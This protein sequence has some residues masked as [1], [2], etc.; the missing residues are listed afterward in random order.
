MVVLPVQEK[1]HL[2][3]RPGGADGFL[4]VQGI[5]PLAGLL[6]DAAAALHEQRGRTAGRVTN[7]LAGLRIQQARQQVGDLRRRVVFPGLAAR[8][9]RELADQEFIG[10]A[11]D[12]QRPHARQRKIQLRLGKVFQ[13]GAQQAVLL[14][15][16]A[17]L[18]GIEADVLKD[19]AQFAA[20][21][22]FQSRQRLIDALAV[23]RLVTMLVEG[24]EVGAL[25]QGEALLLHQE[26]DLLLVAVLL[27][28]PGV[29]IIIDIGHEF[30]EQ[31][32]KDEVLVHA[33]VDG[34]AKGVA[35]RPDGLVDLFLVDGGDRLAHAFFLS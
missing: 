14:L 6:E 32:D 19:V 18:I 8:I 11:D 12:V 31:H 23:A 30:Q 15:F 24:P 17:Q 7:G 16:L 33:G 21:G 27:H 2:G 3:Q 22:I 10:I 34:T 4:P 5:V 9:G 13:Q 28:E 26:S 25:G 20:V 1:V 35:G 29:L